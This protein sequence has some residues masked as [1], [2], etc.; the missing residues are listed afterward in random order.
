MVIDKSRYGTF[1]CPICK[2]TFHDKKK[3]DG[4]IGGAHRKGVTEKGIIKCKHCGQRLR[5]GFNWPKWAVK[6]RNLIC[7]TCKNTQN[8]KAYRNRK[9][10]G[11][12]K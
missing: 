9:R 7:K 12:K 1:E 10:R 3:L 5:E 11:Y 2:R 8:K 6:Q 4:H